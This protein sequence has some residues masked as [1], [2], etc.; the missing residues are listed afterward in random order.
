MCRWLGPRRVAAAVLL[1]AARAALLFVHGGRPQLYLASAGLV[2]GIGWLAATAD[3]GAR[4]S[5]GVPL[6]IAA[7]SIQHAVLG[8]VD[9][10]WRTSCPSVR[11]RHSRPAIRSRRSTTSWCWAACA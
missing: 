9:L 11:C 2:A 7:A 6:G 10:S 4:V 3:R 1:G 8:M 5:P